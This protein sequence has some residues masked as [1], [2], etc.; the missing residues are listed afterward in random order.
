MH[1]K[2]HRMQRPRRIT[3][4][5]VASIAGVDTSTASR[6]L[7]DD[8]G[9]R[10]RI[11]TRDRVL[12]AARNLG[13]QPNPIARGLRTSRSLILG[14]AVPELEN[15][16]FPQIILGA[17]A[18][19]RER[20]YS[21]L[22]SHVDEASADP[23][24]YERLAQVSRMDGLLVAT[25]QEEVSLA[26]SLTRASLPFIVLNRRL[27]GVANYVAF[28]SFAAARIATEHLLAL[29][30][31]R[32]AHLA[33]H[34]MGFNGRRRLAGYRAALVAA[35]IEPDRQFVVPAGY[36]FE[37]GASAMRELLKHRHRPTGIIAAT[38]VTAAG[39]MKVLHSEGIEIPGQISI[40]GIHDAAIADMLNPPLT[41]VR[42]PLQ[43]M[44]ATATRG[45]IEL[46][47]NKTLRVAHTLPPEGLVLRASTGV[48]GATR[49]PK[50]RLNMPV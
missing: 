26:D 21:L 1:G 48:P 23:R 18:A 24:I 34:L 46:I 36:T 50:R 10:I 9:H 41:T 8:A 2:S 35:G 12:A 42:L 4:S 20:G 6:I 45:L 40:V 49:S 22:I 11:A 43:E 32:I 17:E 5:D 13:Y 27:R 47:E 19:A 37:G 38:M 15:P 7:N 30:H 3:L 31:Q 16:V 33:G 14:I 44:G 29:G 25:L 39:A 28:D